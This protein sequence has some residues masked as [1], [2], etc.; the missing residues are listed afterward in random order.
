MRFGPLTLGI[1]AILGMVGGASG[2][3]SS[4]PAAG[5][6]TFSSLEQVD[7]YQ[8]LEDVAAARSMT[9]VQAQN[10]RTTKAL[11]SDPRFAGL[12]DAALKVYESPDHLAIPILK[13][14]TIYN[15]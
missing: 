9:W 15:T 11:E 1:T 7:K 4:T 2:C 14:G 12:K 3:H 6:A 5:S 8:W 13:E 10:A